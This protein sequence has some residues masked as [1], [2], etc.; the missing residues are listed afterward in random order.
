MAS[1]AVWPDIPY[2]EW[3]DTCT[4][5]HLY[6]QIVGKYRFSH[7]PWVNHSWHATLYVDAG[8]FTTGL[9]PDA[10]G[11]TVRFDLHRQVVNAS[12]SSGMTRDF[13]LGAMSVA[14]F[15]QRFK[16]AISGIGGSPQYHGSPN[17]LP[18]AVPFAQDTVQRPWDADAVARFH[19]ALVAVDG[20]FNEFR[21][22][23]VG[24][25]SPVHLFWG[26]FDL[27]V[28]RFSGR[29]APLHPGGIPNLPDAVTR[30]AYSH[31]VSSAGFWPGGGGIEEA[32]FYS[33]AYP[34]PDGFAQ[35]LVQPEQARF[36]ETLGEFV[37]P[38]SVVRAA[39]DPR[40]ALL[41]FLG[42]TYSAASTLGRW[43]SG[44]LEC[45]TG[46]IGKPRAVN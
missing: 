41:E 45:P 14:E 46:T 30:E 1:D 20:V 28:T 35:S 32:C 27:A 17:E 44:D 43:S 24:K 26:S 4:A 38:Y 10:S 3:Q 16:A 13:A 39:L 6:T 7:T 34:A 19:R 29:T 25:V 33:Y 21:S 12:S 40:R 22:G 18:E 8:G 15:D 31:E 36:D 9:I 2:K 37:L 11:I 23:F 5:L 42:S